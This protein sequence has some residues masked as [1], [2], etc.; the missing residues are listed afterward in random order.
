MR[1]ANFTGAILALDRAPITP[2]SQSDSEVRLQMPKH[3]NGYAILSATRAEGSAFGRYLYVPPSL[4]DLAPG[5]ITTVAGIGQ[6]GGE[7]GPATEASLRQ[8]WGMT[9]DA[10]GTLY[11]TDTPNNRVLR[12][13]PDGILEPFA[14]DG[15]SNGPHPSVPTAA[16]DVAIS[17][18]RSIAFDSAGNL[19]VPDGGNY[20]WRVSRDG[21]AEIIAGTGQR[22]SSVSEGV[23]A[24]GSAIGY[25]S[26]VAVDDGDNIYFIDWSNARVRKIDRA[27]ILT[28]I[29]GTGTYGF[30]GD[31]GPATNAQFSLAF[32]D[33]GG[34]AVDHSGNLLLLDHGNHR[35][36]R[37]NLTTG[38][39]DTIVGPTL[40]GH[41]LDNPRAMTVG[42]D[43]AIYFSN[44]SEVY[45][46][47]S[48]GSITPIASGKT[49]F[50]E[51][52][53]IVGVSGIGAP[54][55]FTVDPAGNLLF[56]ESG[57][58]RLRKIDRAT[59]RLSTLAGTGPSVL[60]E[61]GPATAAALIT[62]NLDLKFRN[63][64]ELLI[65]D[66][67]RICSLGSDGRLL[68]IAG[69][70]AS[71]STS[72]TPALDASIGPA[73]IFVGNDGTIDFAGGSIAVFR[74]DPAGFV[75]LTAGKAGVCEFSGDGADAL[76]AGLCQTWDAIRDSNG[77]LLIAD[78]NNNR[79]R[80]IDAGTGIIT[81]F[82]GSGPVNG[83]E[84]YGF[85][86]TCGDGGPATNACINTPY[87]LTFDDAGNLFVCENEQRI[88]KIDRSGIISTFAEVHCTKL[89][90][91]FGHVFAVTG[92]AVAQVSRGGDVALLTHP[93]IGFSGD[94]GPAS[95]AQI[96]ALKQSHGVVADRDG[97]LFFADGDNLR[98]RAIRYGAV[99][100]PPGAAIQATSSGSTIRATVFDANG[101][102]AEGVR[103][104]F[105]APSTGPSCHF[106]NN[107][108]TIGVVT[109]PSG[110][111]T[112][113]CVPNCA[114]S[115]S[116]VVTAQPL[117]AKATATVSLSDTAG[118][119]RHRAARH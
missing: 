84:R 76:K 82:A 113:T 3:D 25:P 35:I 117:T 54:Q 79:I 100:A 119:C 24:K 36:R 78:T 104:D 75:R 47:A 91:A 106:P 4:S 105:T 53:S 97:N 31:G 101:H 102:P 89:G 33:L 93:A 38:L 55:G 34:L 15:F 66:S 30:S 67:N 6:Y 10:S 88:R 32:N 103:V 41:T 20:L 80:K 108:T 98:I 28:T 110:E 58:N 92:N 19:I 2:L 49:G 65:A 73:S 40:N 95:N 39:I 107:A 16:L 77:N 22:A 74:I 13:R 43:D 72:D 96:F 81:T 5:F 68:R 46:R 70:G 26:Y 109:D 8:P 29:A 45:K 114:G 63:G 56:S 7:Y 14:G 9:F 27:G 18:P 23:A 118:P 71:R 44:A 51:D 62:A 17:F 60:G 83:L 59:N 57:V 42:P 11:F 50:S 112:T 52:G 94:G 87:G 116:F 99:L 90:W 115:G 48:D 21:L 111:A 37:I 64:R 86:S 69:N 61:S 85:G 12:I 1:G